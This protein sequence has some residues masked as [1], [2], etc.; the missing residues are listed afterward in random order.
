MGPCAT[1]KGTLLRKLLPGARLPQNCSDLTA[2]L[3]AAFIATRCQR[4]SDVWLSVPQHGIRFPLRPIEARN[5]R[6]HN[7]TVVYDDIKGHILTDRHLEQIDD[8]LLVSDLCQGGTMEVYSS[9]DLRQS[10]YTEPKLDTSNLDHVH[11]PPCLARCLCHL[12]RHLRAY[13]SR[14][15]GKC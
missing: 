2:C 9:S 5:I 3:R 6:W 8:N 11:I 14:G 12:F 15:T 4:L 7:I 1:S 13:G 10:F